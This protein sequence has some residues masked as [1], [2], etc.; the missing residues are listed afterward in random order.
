[1][2]QMKTYF[3]LS[4][5]VFTLIL[6]SSQS[7]AQKIKFGHSNTNEIF[8]LMPEAKEVQTQLE[9]ES[10]KIQD[11]LIAMQTEYQQL[12]QEY[13]E[14]E[15]LLAASPEKW[16]AADKADKEA[17]IRGLEERV[18][19]YQSNAQ[20]SLQETQ[21]KLYNPIRTKIQNA[22]KKVR[23]DNGFIIIFEDQ[24]LLDYDEKTVIDVNPMIKKELGLE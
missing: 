20:T 19:K 22:I 21:M 23:Q 11:R 5:A 13:A 6:F 14:N 9:A 12:I 16:S 7:F 3:K 1:M 4:I 18:T 2:T 17:A 10:K 8:E 15:Q 24:V